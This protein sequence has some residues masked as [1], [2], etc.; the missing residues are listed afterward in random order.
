MD[1]LNHIQQNHARSK[2]PDCSDRILDFWCPGL[3]A[4]ISLPDG[5]RKQ[6]VHFAANKGKHS[7]LRL[8]RLMEQLRRLCQE[9]G[10]KVSGS[11]VVALREPFLE[12]VH[13]RLTYLRGWL[14]DVLGN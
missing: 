4:Q 2:S 6:L 3:D 5:S 10:V 13:G 7:L 8:G 14:A 11:N 12:D 9:S 1:S